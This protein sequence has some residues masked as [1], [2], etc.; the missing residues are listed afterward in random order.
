[1]RHLPR[2][3]T[4]ALLLAVLLATPATA[5]WFFGGHPG[6]PKASH[7]TK[8][9]P[10]AHHDGWGDAPKHAWPKTPPWKRHERLCERLR[11][12]ADGHPGRFRLLL[13]LLGCPPP[14]APAPVPEP[15]FTVAPPPDT[16]LTDAA[17]NA[18]ADLG[19]VEADDGLFRVPYTRSFANP[20]V[21]LGPPTAREAQP[22][23]ARLDRV[24]ADGF[25]LRFAEWEDGDGAHVP[26]AIPYLVIESGRHALADGR[27][28]EA[29][30]LE[31][32]EAGVWDAVAFDTPFDAPPEVFLTVQTSNDADPVVVRARDVTGQGFLAAIFESEGA[33]GTHGAE[34]IGYLAVSSPGSGR[35]A[36]GPD[37]VPFWIGR[38]AADERPVPVLSARLWVEEETTADAE[39]D[40]ETESVSVMA[41]GPQVFAQD[42]SAMDLDPSALRRSAPEHGPVL[43]WGTLPEVDGDWRTVPLARTYTNPVVVVGPMSSNDPAAAVLR[44]RGVASDSFEMRV[45]SRDFVGRPHDAERAFY[46]VTDPG[47]QDLG[48][49]VVEAGHV[50]T[51][52]VARVG[53]AEVVLP[54]PYGVAPG[55]FATVMTD[56]GAQPIA[57]RMFDRTAEGFRVGLEPEEAYAGGLE[58]ETIGWVAIQAGRGMTTDGR[59]I[60]VFDT[61]LDHTPV[62]VPFGEAFVGA[63][64]S[65]LAQI[66]SVN[67]FDSVVPRY[68]DLTPEDVEMHLQEESSAD[69]EIAHRIED[70]SVFVGE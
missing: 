2:G 15:D 56:H 64:P 43:E 61:S 27:A 1:M 29:G 16:T 67:G 28:W 53:Q 57:A 40:H 4:L 63:F 65:L 45:Q 12:R 69:P 35:L 42:V 46:L 13:W 66:V 11:I 18:L 39:T 9:H 32:A 58:N 37:S 54:L 22:G 21:L 24:E 25:R 52:Q 55:V 23:I 70:V 8:P 34:R 68:R 47:I 31:I 38:I 33:D 50:D 3:R 14:T 7:A 36:T 17:G 6:W 60:A 30:H 59:A 20:V 19:T 49:L 44:V 41:L 10:T 62:R 5:G 26:E 51:D 48:G